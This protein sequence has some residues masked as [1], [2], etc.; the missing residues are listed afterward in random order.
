MKI[1]LSCPVEVWEV[2][3]PSPEQEACGLRLFNLTDKTVT[4]VEINV[5]VSDKSG[6]ELRHIIHRCYS[7]NGRPHSAFDAAVAAGY[8]SDAVHAEASAMKVWFDDNT[9]WRK[10]RDPL[11][12][13]TSNVLTPCRDLDMLQYVAGSA[14]VGFPEEQENVWVCVCGRANSPESSVCAR[15]LQ[16]K[17]RIFESFNRGNIREQFERKERQLSLKSRALM[18]DNARLQLQRE[19]EY[20]QKNAKESGDRRLLTALAVTV[21]FALLLFFAGIPALRFCSAVYGM[22]HGR[23]AEAEKVLTELGAFPG[24]EEQL[25]RCRYLRAVQSL[26]GGDPSALAEAADIFREQGGKDA[27][28]LAEAADYERA[29][30]LMEQSEPEKARELFLTLADYRDSAAQATECAYQIACS[31]FDSRFY[32]SA[33]E[34]FSAL[35]DYRDSAE[36]SLLCIYLPAGEYLENGEYDAAITEYGRIPD[37][38]DSREQIRRCY[39]LKGTDL[40]MTDPASAA[41]AYAKAE[42]FCGGAEKAR[43]LRYMLASDA[44]TAGDLSAAAELFELAVPYEDSEDRAIACTYALA[45]QKLS[46]G[47]WDTARELYL[48]LPDGYRNTASR[49]QETRYRP[50]VSAQKNGDWAAAVELYVALGDYKDCV[51]RLEKTRYSWASS[52]QKN[53]D[54]ETAIA[55]YELLGD[56][57]DS[58][59]QLNACRYSYGLKLLQDGEYEK[60]SG[61][62]AVLG[63]YKDSKTCRKEAEYRVAGTLLE[64]GERTA[65]REKF[66][67]LKDY[68]D[69]EEMIRACDYAEA[70]Y[71]RDSGAAE[72][73]AELFVRAGDREDAA[74]QASALYMQLGA[75][76]E[77]AGRIT[78]AAG[79]YVKAGKTPGAAEKAVELYDRYY[80]D[81]STAVTGAMKTG[82]W[83]SALSLMD[84]ITMTDL[85]EKYRFLEKDYREAA[86]H[87]GS[88]LLEEGKP[89]EALPW[90]R[91]AGDYGNT[92]SLLKKA[93]Y[94]LPGCWSDKSGT[95]TAVF[96]ENGTCTVSGKEYCYNVKGYDVYV[97]ENGGEPSLRWR[98]SN[99]GRNALTLTGSDGKTVSVGRTGDAPAES[100]VTDADYTVEDE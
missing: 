39:W 53:G 17:A 57:S 97:W 70:V 47:D 85:P 49:L 59:K 63:D 25:I 43:S 73:A 28:D 8:D 58:P 1:D 18:E 48:R 34:E 5:L 62:F 40:E 3:C 15:C 11:T 13:Y 66:A 81:I 64:Q 78:A 9:V 86:W 95:F 98:M 99:V 27:A 93:C 72:A 45:E 91:K 50:A 41:E 54:W 56:Y 75:E 42:D 44:E 46:A 77:A 71:L 33:W 16:N 83:P 19:E 52:L 89:Y 4:S 92:A 21:L 31:H 74:A 67:A 32:G 68:A 30:L 36:K 6:R 14:A 100:G 29:L 82:D 37:Y 87:V 61:V 80:G 90:L 35:G 55:Q 65:A 60:A 26:G 51:K 22:D 84:S 69:S 79:Y 2:S 76:A 96:R 20:N 7:L 23:A 10:N 12:E 94:T 88:S 24:A 38:K